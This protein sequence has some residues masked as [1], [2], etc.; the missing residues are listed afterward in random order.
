MKL[1]GDIEVDTYTKINSE[2][3]PEDSAELK[4]LQKLK[5]FVPTFYGSQE[6]KIVL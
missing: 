6:G 2:P 1:T 4:S 3:T 5:P